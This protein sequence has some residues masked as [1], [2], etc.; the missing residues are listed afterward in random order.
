VDAHA[1]QL[2]HQMDETRA[3]MDATLTQLEQRVSQMPGALLERQVLGPVR[4]MQ[5]TAARA[6]AWLRVAR[7]GC[8][9]TRGL[10]TGV[11]GAL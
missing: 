2:R 3:A 9:G 7:L 5:E 10:W 8:R 6:T 1:A 4:G 11:A